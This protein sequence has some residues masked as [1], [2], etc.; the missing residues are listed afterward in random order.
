MSEPYTV[1]YLVRWVCNNV[2]M[3]P[4][5]IWWIATSYSNLLIKLTLKKNAYIHYVPFTLKA[6]PHWTQFQIS[7]QLLYRLVFW[8]FQGVIEMEHCPE[9][10]CFVHGS[11][12]KRFLENWFLEDFLDYCSWDKKIGKVGYKGLKHSN[13]TAFYIFLNQYMLI[14]YIN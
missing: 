2:I 7:N 1:V 6:D 14:M 3:I 12:I 10:D 13:L 5:L 4:P 8:Y 9:T 11:V